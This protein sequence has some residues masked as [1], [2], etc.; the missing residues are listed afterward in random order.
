MDNKALENLERLHLGSNM[1]EL[2]NY[3]PI[4]VGFVSV[5]V[6]LI[7]TESK[8]ASNTKEIERLWHTRAEDQKAAR[9][10]RQEQ[11]EILR[12]IR[13]DIKKLMRKDRND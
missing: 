1:N 5:L 4:V 10:N 11:N 7:R 8:V 6:W 12:E 9:E 13:E 3:W 2:L